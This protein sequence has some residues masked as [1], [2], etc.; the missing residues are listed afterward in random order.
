MTAEGHQTGSQYGL[1]SLTT[2]KIFR[3]DLQLLL[4]IDLHG[5]RQ[6]IADLAQVAGLD[7]PAARREY[8][9]DQQ[10]ERQRWIAPEELLMYRRRVE[11]LE[12]EPLHRVSAFAIKQLQQQAH[13]TARGNAACA[14][15]GKVEFQMCRQAW[16]QKFGRAGSAQQEARS[17][18]QGLMNRRQPP[19]SDYASNALPGLGRSICPVRKEQ[20]GNPPPLGFTSKVAR[21]SPHHSFRWTI[22]CRQ[23]QRFAAGTVQ[24]GNKFNHKTTPTP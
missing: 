4:P 13:G 6:Q 15:G 9:P 20:I 1:G 14:A 16:L 17:L 18:C 19:R 7:L 2:E 23:K 10:P 3:T 22:A 5:K 8:A 21:Y 11:L 24:T 12:L